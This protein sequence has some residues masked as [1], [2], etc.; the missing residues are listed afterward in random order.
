MAWE[1]SHGV[2]GS[3]QFVGVITSFVIS[4]DIAT[5]GSMGLKVVRGPLR[6]HEAWPRGPRNYF[7]VTV[8]S[9][10]QKYIVLNIF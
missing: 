9:Y 10:N 1:L 6:A 3:P 7:R 2:Y 8:V 5:R 4:D